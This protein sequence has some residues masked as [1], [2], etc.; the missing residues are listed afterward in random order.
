MSLFTVGGMVGFAFGPLMI[1]PTLIAF[2]IHG[3]IVV[4]LPVLIMAITVTYNLPRLAAAGAR[5]SVGHAA[6]AHAEG[7][8]RWGDFSRLA[9]VVIMRSTTFFGLNTFIPL[10]W[11]HILHGSKSGGG[12]ALS[13]LAAFVAV[14][15]LIG[16][17]MADRYGRKT[18]ISV[19]LGA[20]VPL[21][22]A[23]VNA[24]A[25]STASMLLLPLGLA[26]SASNSVVVVMGQE[27]LPNR[28]G[29]AAGVTLGLSMT[30]GGLLMP[31]FGSI[32][33][34]YGLSTTMF[35]L[36]LVPILG[37]V[38]S[39]TLRETAVLLPP[40]WHGAAGKPSGVASVLGAETTPGGALR[41]KDID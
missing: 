8:E 16:G 21:L 20:L 19:S 37:F 12:F 27:Y 13:A 3:S 2:G 11:T 31:V 9:A 32:A 28:V 4:A 22:F 40:V 38:L 6:R 24:K 29:L 5:A 1:T 35:L 36:C 15:T 23:F 39:L 30:I 18:V 25:A 41:N 33:D 34:H 10:Y 14:G 7:I 17:R 26:L